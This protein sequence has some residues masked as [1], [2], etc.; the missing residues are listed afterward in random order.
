LIEE[1]DRSLKRWVESVIDDVSVSFAPPSSA[2]T[3]RGVGLYLYELGNAPAA[4]TSARPPVQFLLRY[5][6]TAWAERAEEAHALLGELVF[7][8]LSHAELEVDLLAPPA[9]IWSAFG[10]APRPSFVVQVVAR[11]EREERSVPRVREPLILQLEHMTA[12]DE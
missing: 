11:R 3:G 10:V 7:A 6:V 12:V 2:D 4:R 9:A 5:L 1:I 8:A